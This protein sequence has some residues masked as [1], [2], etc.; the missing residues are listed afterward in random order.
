MTGQTSNASDKNDKNGKNDKMCKDEDKDKAS[1][2]SGTGMEIADKNVN[3]E[4]NAKNGDKKAENENE[5]EK[6][7]DN[8]DSVDNKCNKHDI[9]SLLSEMKLKTSDK[10]LF[11]D[12]VLNLNKDDDYKKEQ[13]FYEVKYNEI[14]Q[15]VEHLK[16]ENTKL[17]QV[18]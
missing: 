13:S 17:K 5:N 7:G 8:G 12:A 1:T 18:T 9:E 3:K 2:A 6:G 14:V 10:I 11:R 16:Q 4:E 15:Q